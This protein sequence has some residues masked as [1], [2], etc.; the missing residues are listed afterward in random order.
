M[1]TRAGGGRKPDQLS[2]FE[3][4][5]RV[6]LSAGASDERRSVLP[7]DDPEAARLAQRLSLLAPLIRMG[8][9]SWTFPGWAN[10]VYAGSPSA[11]DLARGGLRAYA[12]HPLF[13]T[14]GIDRSYYAPLTA[15]Q[16]AAYAADLPE[17][18]L[19]VSKVWEGLTTF[20]FP[21]HPRFGDR[22][23]KENPRFLDPDEIRSTVIAPYEAAF[24]AHAGPFVFEI[25]PIPSGRLPTVDRFT[26]A[27]ERLLCALPRQ[28]SYAFELR[29]RE[30][31]TPRYLDTL[32]A[33]GA[34]HVFNFWSRMPSIGAQ[35]NTPGALSGPFVVARLMLP[36][37]A[38]YETQ[39]QAFAPF[40]RI[41]S[42]Q[43]A[44][45]RDIVVLARACARAQKAL[46][47]LVNNKA[48]GSAPL[49]VRALALDIANDLD[50]STLPRE[51]V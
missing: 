21:D 7:A 50:F 48:E 19:A 25:A 15:P 17:G 20:A 23:A 39:K 51:K 31:L 9:S 2:L 30:L 3:A 14:V 6:G 8:T 43:A 28:F 29:N 49:T 24:K 27:I 5:P 16:L 18:F 45:R 1:R 46:F 41:V 38:S 33:H 26:R 47:I 36:P 4:E 35:L 32:R 10:L 42:A 40:D 13:R 22:A 12:Q 44:M 34:A 11:A 37:G